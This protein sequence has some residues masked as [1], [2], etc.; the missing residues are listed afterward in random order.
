MG[1]RVPFCRDPDV[2]WEASL[3]RSDQ[4]SLRINPHTLTLI[5]QTGEQ[6][7]RQST[8]HFINQRGHTH[9]YRQ[10]TNHRFRAGVFPNCF[11]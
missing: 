4:L 10:D 9:T 3:R 8:P 1:Q 6:V 2:G 11:K 7:T 5:L